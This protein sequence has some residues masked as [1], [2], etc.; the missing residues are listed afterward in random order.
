MIEY[1]LLNLLL[2][3][4]VVLIS[5]EFGNSIY[6]YI[7]SKRDINL[8]KIIFGYIS[9]I[10]ELTNTVLVLFI[11]F[12]I[13]IY[14]KAP[15]LYGTVLIVPVSL[16][17]MFLMIRAFSF[18][19][20]YE[21]DESSITFRTLYALCSLFIPIFLSTYFS[22]SIY[23]NIHQVGG[24]II[25]SLSRIFF[26]PLSL[27]FMIFAVLNIIYLSSAF[28]LM[29]TKKD[30]KIIE[31]VSHIFIILSSIMLIFVSISFFIFQNLPFFNN[32]LNNYFLILFLYLLLFVLSQGLLIF[33]EYRNI[34]SFSLLQ[35]F[36]LFL[37]YVFGN[38]PYIMYNNI[39][40]FNINSPLVIQVLL[41][42]SI[43]ALI[44]S[45]PALI[46]FIYFIKR[47]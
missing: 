2:F 46:V 10:W 8:S 31:E 9:P 20:L 28:L 13:G 23:N 38:Y 17:L 15:M 6:Y 42:V 14:P 47:K 5:I 7:Y 36:L 4:Y 44:I 21:Y 35:M 34:F 32:I 3:V 29:Y 41:Y 19:Y 40:I 25:Y 18:V 26:S 43:I 27:A 24:S 1:I 12:L 33:K 37:M 22:V 16:A 30:K 45:I 11:V 39:S